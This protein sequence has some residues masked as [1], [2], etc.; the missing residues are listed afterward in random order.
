MAIIPKW[1]KILAILMLVFIIYA[2]VK[3]N[4]S[5]K[6]VSNKIVTNSTKGLMAK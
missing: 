2:I 6:I 5:N 3:V 4:S 1:V